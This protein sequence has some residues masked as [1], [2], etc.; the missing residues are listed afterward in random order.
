M[1]WRTRRR[2]FWKEKRTTHQLLRGYSGQ[3][4]QYEGL[5]CDML[6][7]VGSHNGS[8]LTEDGMR[9]NLTAPESL[10]AV[11]FVRE[12]IIQRLATPAALT[13]QESEIPRRVPPGQRGCF[14]AIGPMRGAWRKIRGIQ[15]S[16]ARWA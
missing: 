4:K 1:N 3:F 7:F 14:I 13:Y 16:W 2:R 8:F 10:Q 12:Q 6:E 5:V 15:K 9:S 11:R